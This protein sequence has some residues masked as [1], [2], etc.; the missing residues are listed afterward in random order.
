M[1]PQTAARP[2]ASG[3][4]RPALPDV[5]AEHLEEHGFLCLQRRRLIVSVEYPLR[6]L[7]QHDARVEA[8]WDGLV[9]A[10]PPAVALALERLGGDDP[11]EVATAA[12]A[13]LVLGRP[14]PA[15]VLER[16]AAVP[17]ELAA[18]WR[19][20]LRGAPAQR[21]R[22]ALP[23][24]E[25]A[26][27]PGPG[28]GVAIDALAWH[29]ALPEPLADAAARHADAGARGSL[30]RALPHAGL[31]E[32]A[33][34]LAP[35][36]GDADADVARRALWGLALVA[37]EEAVERARRAARGPAP[38]PFAVRVLGLLGE[39]E[40]V[41]AITA[42]A[43]TDSGRPAAFRAL[44]D[45][46]TPEAVEALIRLLAL[47]DAELRAVAGEALEAALGAVPREAPDAPP[48]PREAEAHWRALA[49]ALPRGAR[50]TAGRPRP[51]AGPA[52]EQPMYWHWRAAIAGR[53]RQAPW[54]AREV[55]DGFFGA[56][57]VPDARPGE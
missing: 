23:A 46:G 21:V 9:T 40:D 51:W 44:A 15:A 48:T 50:V 25:L 37:P 20:A 19:E 6:R 8:H 54:L 13:W 12:R 16:L 1:T 26:R 3:P 49:P 53:E 39:P 57:P 38:E 28:L 17:P 45:L 36:L 18:S 10:G 31:E 32:P 56:V 47:P 35:L 52:S 33:G 30:A 22:E 11:W 42:A 4:A 27:L 29:G 5:L 2:A 34:R 7:P 41:G 14:A 24:R 55:P 43:A